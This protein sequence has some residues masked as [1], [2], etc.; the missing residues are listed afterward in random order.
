M[1]EYPCRDGG[2]RMAL[3]FNQPRWTADDLPF[4][5]HALTNWVDKLAHTAG[6]SIFHSYCC[7]ARVSMPGRW[8]ANNQPFCHNTTYTSTH[9]HPFPH[10]QSVVTG[11][12]VADFTL[13]TPVPPCL[14]DFS[15]AR[16]V[17][18]WKA[19]A[20]IGGCA[21]VGEDGGG[22]ECHRVDRGLCGC[23]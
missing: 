1:L 11:G 23:R 14:T 10:Y 21:V 18:V 4:N 20:S 9:N 16:S 8:T 13:S 22:Q 12:R 17:V 5:Q 2:W 15:W 7:H 6:E 3:P 19:A